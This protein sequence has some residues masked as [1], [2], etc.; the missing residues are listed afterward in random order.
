MGGFCVGGLTAYIQ[1]VLDDRFTSPEEITSQLGVPVLAMV[2]TLEALPGEGLETVH[3]NAIPN[4][5][6]TEAFRTLR[7]SLSLGGDVCDRILVSSSEPGDGKTTISANLSVALAQVG[8][9]TLVIDADLRRPGFTTLIN[10][11]G[12]YKLLHRIRM[13]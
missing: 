12:N 3:T 10:L 4:S 11:K 2:K 7:T 5:V 9:R 13:P 6:Q 8:L 1:D